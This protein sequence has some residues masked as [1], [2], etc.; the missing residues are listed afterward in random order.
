MNKKWALTKQAQFKAVYE[1]GITR[2]DKYIVIRA[3]TNN[4]ETTRFGYSISKRVG[5]AVT[6]NRVRRL[7]REIARVEPIKQGLDIVFIARTDSADASYAQLRSSVEKLL[8]QADLLI[9]VNEKS[10]S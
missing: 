8:H 9:E 6:R 3:L 1:S 4:I 10:S 5:N 7:L 2:V